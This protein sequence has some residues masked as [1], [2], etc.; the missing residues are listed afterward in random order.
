M[1]GLYLRLMEGR[2]IAGSV[3]Y[4]DIEVTFLERYNILP[5]QL[6][7]QDPDFIEQVMARLRAERE[8]QEKNKP[9]D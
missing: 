5:A 7:L 8:Y 6:Y 9:K 2:P 3:G 1:Q 4:Y